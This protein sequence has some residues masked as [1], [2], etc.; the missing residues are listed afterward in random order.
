MLDPGAGPPHI[1]LEGEDTEAF[2]HGYIDLGELVAQN[3]GIALDP[4]PRKPGLPPVEAEFGNKED[5]PNPFA[6][7]ASLTKLEKD[8]K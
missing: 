6:K 2:I 1:D 7:L 8:K 3:L 4:Y 5:K